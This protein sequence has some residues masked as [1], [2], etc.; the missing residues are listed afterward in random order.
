MKTQM[1]LQRPD[2]FNPQMEAAGVFCEYEGRILFLK[3]H[4]D[5][6]EGL[7]WGVPGG[8][9]EP[10]ETAIDAACRELGEEAGI[11]V[12][13]D[14]LKV[15]APQFVRRPELDFIFHMFYLP[16]KEMPALQI[17]PNESIEACWVNLQ[18]SSKIPL[19]SGG[20]EALEYFYLWKNDQK[21]S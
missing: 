16:L 5:K 18:E 6:I 10:G 13:P 20:R 19:I 7:T 8:K 11:Y 12:A 17:A 3:R 9:T 15:I 21:D 4:A 14:D 2:D 1:F